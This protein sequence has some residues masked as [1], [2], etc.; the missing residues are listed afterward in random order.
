MILLLNGSY[1]GK[2]PLSHSPVAVLK[3]PEMVQVVAEVVVVVLATF[4][5]SQPY[6]V[7]QA[8]NILEVVVEV[9]IPATETP[10]D[11]LVIHSSPD[12]VLHSP[13][14]PSVG[15][16]GNDRLCSGSIVRGGHGGS[17]LG[18]LIS[19]PGNEGNGGGGPGGCFPGD[20]SKNQPSILKSSIPTQ[21]KKNHILHGMTVPLPEGAGRSTFEVTGVKYAKLVLPVSALVMAGLMI[22]FEIASDAVG[23]FESVAEAVSVLLDMDVVL[24]SAA[25][26]ETDET[27]TPDDMV[28]F[29]PAESVVTVLQ[30]AAELPFVLG[31]IVVSTLEGIVIESL[32]PVSTEDPVLETCFG[33]PVVLAIPAVC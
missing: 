26:D 27:E 23:V 13:S 1:N 3:S 7:A 22:E 6:T 29:S 17:G 30:G 25:V 8:D 9:T 28:V 12:A 11:V 33:V 19:R 32:V 5:T 31:P 21:L 10:Y 15:L 2:L 16:G 14:G 24:M 18:M 4:S 20:S